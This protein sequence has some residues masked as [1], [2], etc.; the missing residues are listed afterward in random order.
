MAL[1]G[2]WVSKI[3]HKV[4]GYD[5]ITLGSMTASHISKGCLKDILQAGVEWIDMIE[6]MI[7]LCGNHQF[8]TLCD[9]VLTIIG[10]YHFTSLS[11]LQYYRLT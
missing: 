11:E 2:E 3:P 7:M 10:D 9:V 6:K 4:K 1:D 5:V 8:N